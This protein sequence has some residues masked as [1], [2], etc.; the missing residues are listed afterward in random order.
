MDHCK[1]SWIR[2][3]T[4][5]GCLRQ[6][7]ILATAQEG[8]IPRFM[9]ECSYF[10]P[11]VKRCGATHEVG[12]ITGRTQAEVWLERHSPDCWCSGVTVSA[13]AKAPSTNPCIIL[14]AAGKAFRGCASQGLSSQ[15]L[16]LSNIG[17]R[18]LKSGFQPSTAFTYVGHSAMAKYCQVASLCSPDGRVL[19]Q[20]RKSRGCESLADTC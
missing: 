16:S 6:L 15:V 13:A 14:S 2:S 4:P 18:F 20:A 10:A 17:A 5:A 8:V 19:H 9:R 11:V 1:A 12:F 7:D 3:V